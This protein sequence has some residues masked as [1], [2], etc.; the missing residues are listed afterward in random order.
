MKKFVKDMTPQE[1]AEH[2]LR[3]RMAREQRTYGIVGGVAKVSYWGEDDGYYDFW[4]EFKNGQAGLF[5]VR[6]YEKSAKVYKA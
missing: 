6:L 5:S 4:V 1:R 3:R 2:A